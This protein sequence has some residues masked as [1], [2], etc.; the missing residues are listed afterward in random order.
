MRRERY[1]HRTQR[2]AKSSIGDA[3]PTVPFH[4]EENLPPTSPE[5]HHH[6]SNDTRQKIVLPIWLDQHKND[7]ALVVSPFHLYNALYFQQNLEF[8]TA[9][10]ESSLGSS[11]G[12]RVR[13]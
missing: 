8:P 1:F 10:K 13:W 4:V 3:L 7:P 12:T 11:I 6:I 5:Q 2:K 9:A